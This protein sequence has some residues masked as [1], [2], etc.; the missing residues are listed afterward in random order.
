MLQ[1]RIGENMRS[2]LL[3]LVGPNKNVRELL[4][5]SGYDRFLEI[6]ESVDSAIQSF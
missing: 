6:H 4:A 2:Q 5:T 1:K 3:K